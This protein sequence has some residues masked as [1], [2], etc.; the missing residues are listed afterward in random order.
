VFPSQGHLLLLEDGVQRV[1]VL[2]AAVTNP[3]LMSLSLRSLCC[4]SVGHESEASANQEGLTDLSALP[5][6]RVFSR[7]RRAFNRCSSSRMS[8]F[9]CLS[10][11]KSE[12]SERAYNIVTPPSLAERRQTFKIISDLAF[13]IR[14]LA[15]FRRASSSA[16][17]ILFS[18]WILSSS[19]TKS[20][21]KG[22]FVVFF[23]QVAKRSSLD[24]AN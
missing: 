13:S 16:I 14:D 3:R 5:W 22:D 15:I 9:S 12:N 23:F 18:S 7:A 19:A 1:L 10:A 21:A 24:F 8:F 11:S 2:L 4:Q 6:V 20:T 17:R